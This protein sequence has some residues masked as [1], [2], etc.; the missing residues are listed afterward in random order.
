MNK[1]IEDIT[2]GVNFRTVKKKDNITIQIDERLMPHYEISKT[3]KMPEFK[4]GD[5]VVGVEH[6]K[7]G[8]KPFE[9]VAKITSVLE[10][11]GDKQWYWFELYEPKG[12]TTGMV[13][14]DELINVKD[15]PL[16]TGLSEVKHGTS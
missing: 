14:E 11:K 5:E 6:P 8:N 16:P 9:G 1:K 2:N 3:R 15:T 10:S 12:K 4:V 13:S 7:Y